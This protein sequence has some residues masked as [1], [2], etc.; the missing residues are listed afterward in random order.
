MM[1]IVK[2]LL[3]QPRRGCR[4]LADKRMIFLDSFLE[5][6]TEKYNKKKYITMQFVL[7]TFCDL[8]KTPYCDTGCSV[9]EDKIALNIFRN[10]WF[11]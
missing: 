11:F 7:K 4:E 8:K 9:K 5:N 6:C 1:Y 2:R 10:H 3:F